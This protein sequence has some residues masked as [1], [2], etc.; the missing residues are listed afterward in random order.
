MEKKENIIKT[1]FKNINGLQYFL[2]YIVFNYIIFG[3]ALNAIPN[4]NFLVI[5]LA[6]LCAIIPFIAAFFR[7]KRLDIPI[8]LYFLFISCLVLGLFY[9][10]DIMNMK[11]HNERVRLILENSGFADYFPYWISGILH[12]FCI[13][14]FNLFL[15]FG[16]S[17]KKLG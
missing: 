3:F 13:L 10:I 5:S 6:F 2:V 17:K 9:P 1:F 15:I 7:F 11:E 8:F 4:D 14:P 12:M 16:N